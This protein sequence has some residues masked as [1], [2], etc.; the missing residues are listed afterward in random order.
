[1]VVGSLENEFALSG[2]N[3]FFRT[4]FQLSKIDRRE[5]VEVILLSKIMEKKY[6]AV[7][8]IFEK[9]TLQFFSPEI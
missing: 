2:A 8:V 7:L 3:S 1:M 9:Y 5:V 4:E 6:D